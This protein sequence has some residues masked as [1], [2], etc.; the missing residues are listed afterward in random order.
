MS[1]F[2]LNG[3]KMSDIDQLILA[4]IFRFGVG[5]KMDGLPHFVFVLSNRGANLIA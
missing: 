2:F 4:L 5:L 3:F 1:F